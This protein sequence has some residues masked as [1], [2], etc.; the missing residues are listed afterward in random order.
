MMEVF[1]DIFTKVA[2][3]LITGLVIAAF[4]LNSRVQRLET[5]Y[6]IRSTSE[7]HDSETLQSVTLLIAKV[8]TLLETAIKRLDILEKHTFQL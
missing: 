1:N 7:Q 2:G 4:H 5:A 6:S 3:S 8:D